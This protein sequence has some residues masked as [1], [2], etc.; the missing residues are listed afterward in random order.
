MRRAH[1]AIIAA[2]L[3]AGSA[4]AADAP[5]AASPPPPWFV[6]ADIPGHDPKVTSTRWLWSRE[7]RTL[8]YCRR[9]AASGEFTCAHDVS[10]PDGRW[11]LRKIQDQP[12]PGIASSAAFYSP[13]RDQALA[14][15]AAEDGTFGCE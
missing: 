8:R 11:V 12:A 9:D 4:H 7:G 14:C 1:P 10:L 3:L 5:G 2:L 6:I 15:R 13:D